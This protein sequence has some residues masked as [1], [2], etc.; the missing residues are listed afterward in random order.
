MS[1]F[2]KSYAAMNFTPCS[3]FPH[4]NMNSNPVSNNIPGSSMWISSNW[5]RKTV[6]VQLFLLVQR[7]EDER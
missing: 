6:M 1:N 5:S 7:D 2:T 3:N 4:L